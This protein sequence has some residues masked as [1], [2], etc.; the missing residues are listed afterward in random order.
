MSSTPLLERVHEDVDAD[1]VEVVPPRSAS[2]RPLGGE[3]VAAIGRLCVDIT[4][5]K[6]SKLVISESDG[7]RPVD[8][9]DRDFATYA[10][11]REDS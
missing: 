4:A 10:E 7:L 9:L 3:V 6:D 11:G 8:D 1:W 2:P 5:A